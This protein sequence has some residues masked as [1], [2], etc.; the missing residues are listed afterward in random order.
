MSHQLTWRSYKQCKQY[1][2][3]SISSGISSIHLINTCTVSGTQPITTF[4]FL[5]LYSAGEKNRGMQ[6]QNE[7]NWLHLDTVRYENRTVYRMKATERIHRQTVVSIS[8]CNQTE[9]DSKLRVVLSLGSITWLKKSQISKAN[10]VANA[11]SPPFDVFDAHSASLTGLC[12]SH[13]ISPLPFFAFS[14][15]RL[16]GPPTPKQC[17]VC[18]TT[19]LI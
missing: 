9:Q 7:L 10:L 2:T 13:P 19:P 4:P 6:L 5:P 18:V 16:L 11:I 3:S 15:I 8:H 14:L 12:S 1:H 17:S